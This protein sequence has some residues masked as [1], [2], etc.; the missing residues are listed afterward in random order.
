[1]VYLPYQ[2]KNEKSFDTQGADPKKRGTNDEIKID[3]KN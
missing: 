3:C 2:M 1:M